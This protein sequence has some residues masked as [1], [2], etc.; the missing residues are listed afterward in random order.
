[1]PKLE[2]YIEKDLTQYEEEIINDALK[3]L[4]ERLE[5]SQDLLNEPSVVKRYLSIKLAKVE[6]EIFG[7][8]FLDSQNKLI[9]AN[10]IFRGTLAACP[11]YPREIV[12]AALMHNAASVILYHNHP[13]GNA[14]PSAADR[15]LTDTLK[16]VLELVDIK[17]VDHII[18]AGIKTFSFNESGFL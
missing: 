7:V 18:I 17:V 2:K 3:I 14:Y 10:E 8:V 11:I 15:D 9:V 4:S 6:H 13:S 12:K 16:L 5:K 1:M